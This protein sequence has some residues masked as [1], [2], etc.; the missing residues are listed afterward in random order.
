MDDPSG[1]VTDRS[2]S[3][4]YPVDKALSL[5]RTIYY[6]PESVSAQIQLFSAVKNICSTFDEILRYLEDGKVDKIVFHPMTASSDRK[7]IVHWAKV[8]N[9]NIIEQLNNNFPAKS[10]NPNHVA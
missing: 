10:Y 1:S 8:F 7:Y 6:I 9:P 4:Q 2:Q 3:F 5:E